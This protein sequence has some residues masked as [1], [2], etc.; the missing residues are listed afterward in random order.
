VGLPGLLRHPQATT[1]A[2]WQHLLLTAAAVLRALRSQVITALWRLET[3]A[4]ADADALTNA[5]VLQFERD[6]VPWTNLLGYG[7]DNTNVV[8]GVHSS[9]RTKLL[10]S[11][12]ERM[13]RT[14]RPLPGQP[15]P[16]GGCNLLAAG[17]PAQPVVH[18]LLCPLS[19]A[20]RQ[21][22]R[23]RGAHVPEC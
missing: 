23:A 6:N 17:A 20:H 22:Q 16:R 21:A 18:G 9:V 3:P 15:A 7:S 12:L 8:A 10:V 2:Q 14:K 13:R 11:E 19:G 4:A 5:V 1:A